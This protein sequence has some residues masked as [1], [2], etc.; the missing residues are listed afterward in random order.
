MTHPGSISTPVPTRSA[1][2][3][4]ACDTYVGYV[5]R[6]LIAQ[7]ADLAQAW[8]V[9][10][11]AALE[12]PRM[13]DGSDPV[14]PGPRVPEDLVR[15]LAAALQGGQWQETVMR[16]GWTAG[17]RAFWR[18]IS[19]YQ[20]LKELDGG[21]ALLLNAID[22][23]TREYQ[24]PATVSDG[25]VI[26]RRLS[27]AAS[28]LR[29]SA[30]GGYTRAMS[31]DLRQRYRSIRHDLRNPLGTIT[32][33][34]ALMDDESVPEKTRQDPR[35]RAMLARNVRSMEAKIAAALG[36]AAAQLPTVAVQMTSLRD[37]ACAVRGD[38]SAAADGVT[39]IVADDLPTF[40]LDSAG[41]ELLLKA[42]VIALARCAEGNVGVTIALEQLG[43][44]S[45]TLAV[46]AAPD[47]PMRDTPDL[48]FAEEL[49]ARLGG[50]LAT[51]AGL[52]VLLEIPI[53][54]RA[55]DRVTDQP[56]S[57]GGTV[58]PRREASGRDPRDDVARERQ[59]PDREPRAL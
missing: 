14:D 49:T 15:T 31:D 55:G 9:R 59:R 53:D 56:V 7:A 24:G 25:F 16:A 54:A 47:T 42:V 1:S 26:S 21:V 12:L 52:R 3:A 17:T 38:L 18:G 23:A 58:P 5:V 46:Y 2:P 36:D 19:L 27:D 45:A 10:G 51:G 57:R 35:M 37:L 39:V 44:R 30:A 34:V 6:A 28:L 32:S 40:P 48:S 20:L 50:R 13:D 33:A 43:T 41:L 8:S 22:T 4:D 11:A 29:L